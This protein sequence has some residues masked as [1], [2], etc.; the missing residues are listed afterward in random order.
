MNAL[1][2]LSGEDI[3]APRVRHGPRVRQDAS[4]A[5]SNETNSTCTNS[6][7]GCTQDYPILE[8]EI[9]EAETVTTDVWT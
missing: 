3:N 8:F 5:P 4:E 9:K 1:Y 6:T 7:R 2:W